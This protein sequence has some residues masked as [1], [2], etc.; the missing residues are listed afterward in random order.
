MYIKRLSLF[1]FSIKL[2]EQEY[3]VTKTGEQMWLNIQWE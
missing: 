3:Q 2:R 1:E